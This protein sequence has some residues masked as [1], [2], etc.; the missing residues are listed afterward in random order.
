MV[1]LIAVS[2]SQL[3]IRGDIVVELAGICHR[4]RKFTYLAVGARALVRVVT[5]R[6]GLRLRRLGRHVDGY[7]DMCVDVKFGMS[8]T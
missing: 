5:R 2:N 1:A 7:A 6:R 3:D 8:G 4:H